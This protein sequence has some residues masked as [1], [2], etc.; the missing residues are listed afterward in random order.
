MFPFIVSFNFFN[1]FQICYPC[2]FVRAQHSIP[3]FKISLVLILYGRR[4]WKLKSQ[5]AQNLGQHWSK[6]MEATRQRRGFKWDVLRDCIYSL[7]YQ[8][9]SPGEPHGLFRCLK[10]RNYFM[11]ERG[12]LGWRR[13][14][15]KHIEPWVHL[16]PGNKNSVVEPQRIPEHSTGVLTGS[17]VKPRLFSGCMERGKRREHQKNCDSCCKK[18]HEPGRQF[19]IV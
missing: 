3:L 7:T 11:G 2:V 6:E 1:L 8:E 18:K 19:E 5:F 17:Q 12:W 16:R 14:Q 4:D 15:R 13:R 10:S 9:V